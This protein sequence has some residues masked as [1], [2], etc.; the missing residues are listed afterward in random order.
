MTEKYGSGRFCC[1]ACANLRQPSE[2]TKQKISQSTKGKKAYTNA[3]TLEV[4]YFYNFEVP[5]NYIHGNITNTI[6]KSI[7]DNQLVRQ[8][9]IKHYHY[10]WL[11]DKVVRCQ[12]KI[13][14]KILLELMANY[15]IEHNKAVIEQY[16]NLLYSKSIG[17][18]FNV[19]NQFIF[20]KYYSVMCP[21]HLRAHDGHVF[22]HIL[23]GEKLLD[24]PLDKY[25]IVHHKNK[26]KLDNTFNNI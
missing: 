11:K 6:A 14:K 24:R 10:I 22:V 13:S 20:A 2:N 9:P 5:E 3:D 18:T 21:E 16:D 19:V 25:E 12:R 17:K 15:I 7:V 8:K 26:N 4:K 1:R 23:L